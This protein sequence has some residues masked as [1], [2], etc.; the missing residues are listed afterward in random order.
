MK[1]QTKKPAVKKTAK[2]TTKK[3]VSK[4]P[5]MRETI[6]K[7]TKENTYLTQAL[8]KSRATNNKLQ[9]AKDNALNECDLLDKQLQLARTQSVRV[10][11]RLD[12]CTN[13]IEAYI[14]KGFF[15]RVWIAMSRVRLFGI[16]G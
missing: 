12:A 10:S 15:A 14:E 7:L 2:Q 13:K 4:K 3:P 9:S 8:E 11:N 1:K 5:T 16:L 6:D